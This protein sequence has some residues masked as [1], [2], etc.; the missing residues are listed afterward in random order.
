MPTRFANYVWNWILLSLNALVFF[1]ATDA[2]LAIGS[3]YYEVTAKSY[4]ADGNYEKAREL[5]EKGLQENPDSTELKALLAAVLRTEIETLI[6]AKKVNEANYLIDQGIQRFPDNPVFGA[7]LKQ[8]GLQKAEASTKSRTERE[9]KKQVEDA[10]FMQRAYCACMLTKK[11]ALSRIDQ[12]K[13]ASAISGVVDMK[14]LHGAGQTVQK[15]SDA[16]T[17]I[18]KE[19]PKKKVSI[20]DCSIK[21]DSWSAE[22]DCGEFY[23]Q[24][25]KDIEKTLEK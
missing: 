16:L 15:S 1:V 20:G 18:E 25:S 5:I 8:V 13:K 22:Y 12:E 21:D 24:N 23:F 7:L 17:F 19:A 3:E 10:K 2:A 4:S 9:Q 6:K 14:V 11:R